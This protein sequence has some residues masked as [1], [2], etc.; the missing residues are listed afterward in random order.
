MPNER[1]QFSGDTS[2]PTVE[3]ENFAEELVNALTEGDMERY[4]ELISIVGEEIEHPQEEK[5][6]ELNREDSGQEDKYKRTRKGGA[7]VVEESLE[8]G[9]YPVSVL[10]GTT[11]ARF[12]QL[13]SEEFPELGVNVVDTEEEGYVRVEVEDDYSDLVLDLGSDSTV[14]ALTLEMVEQPYSHR[15]VKKMEENGKLPEGTA[16]RLLARHYKKGMEGFDESGPMAEVFE[17]MIDELGV[18]PIDDAELDGLIEQ[19][20]EDFLEERSEV[21][22]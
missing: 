21:P 17:D 14:S 2:E 8:D 7:E 15:K 4:K 16:D 12:Y 3:E 5:L 20:V 1:K 18:E 9:P 22:E 13:L 6:K 11:R 10:R 19:A